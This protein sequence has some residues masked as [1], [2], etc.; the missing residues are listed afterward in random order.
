MNHWLNDS[1][2]AEELTMKA[3]KKALINFNSCRKD[4][5]KFST[6]V[7]TCARNEILDYLKVNT[8]KPILPGLSTQEQ[9]VISLR[10]AAVVNNRMI[11]R[12]LGLSESKVGTIV[13]QSLCKL[14][15]SMEVPA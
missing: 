14:R 13:R 5:K 12:L 10:L 8:V 4:E 15:D 3:L 1:R 7:F 6:G 2:I 11:S 9:E